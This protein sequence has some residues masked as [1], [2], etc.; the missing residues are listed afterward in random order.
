MRFRTVVLLSLLAS[1]TATDA[2]AHACL[3]EIGKGLS[4]AMSEIEAVHF[5]NAGRSLL[6][7]DGSFCGFFTTSLS[8]A[9]A[10]VVDCES[11]N[12]C[13]LS[14]G[15]CKLDA[16]EYDPA[17]LQALSGN[18]DY[19]YLFSKQQACLSLTASQC[20]SD[21]SCAFEGNCGLAN[22]YFAIWVANKCPT[23][24]SIV[25]EYLIDEGIT[26]QDVQDEADS[27]GIEISPEFKAEMNEQGVASSAALLSAKFITMF[28]AV[29]LAFA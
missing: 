17:D 11:H 23:A 2:S 7:L 18:S 13:S 16:G 20:L 9:I 6:A 19:I 25:S 24:A 28:S 22:V 12:G 15:E 14:E 5:R 21:A 8:C 10:D 29:A 4:S 1:V 3:S 27:A 26:Q